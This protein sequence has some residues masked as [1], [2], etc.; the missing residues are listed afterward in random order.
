MPSESP[1]SPDLGPEWALLEAVAA[2]AATEEDAARFAERLASGRV[3]TA[4]LVDQA[5]RHKMVFHLE[6]FLEA[7]GLEWRLPSGVSYGLPLLLGANRYRTSL[8]RREAARIAAALH[9]EGLPFAYTKGIILESAV[10]GGDGGRAMSDMD[11]MI[12]PAGRDR[13]PR[14]LEALGYRTG[15]FHRSRGEVVPLDRKSAVMY[16]LHPDHLPHFARATGDPVVPYVAVDVANSLTWFDSPWQV[17]VGP[18]LERARPHPLPGVDAAVPAL[19]PATHFLFTALHLF[20]EGW[21]ENSIQSGTDV[22]LAKFSDL[23]HAWAAW[24]PEI[25]DELRAMLDRFGLHEPVLWVLEHLDRTFG[26]G[27][28]EDLGLAGRV[29]EEWLHSAK[30]GTGPLLHWRGTMRQRLH[31]R[32]R[33]SLLAEPA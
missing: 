21:F 29:T 10:H 26:T 28:C 31:S 33:A 7:H 27:V 11:L 18:C 2:G 24:G 8:L 14:V 15:H 12:E 5:M 32:N 22:S 6:R 25:R 1:A 4:E 9:D 19:D 23:H 16:T 17:P 20:R 30:P 13:V 3:D